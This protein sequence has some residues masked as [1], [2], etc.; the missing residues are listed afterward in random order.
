MTGRE[1]A[2][3][4]VL[5]VDVGTVRLGTAICERLDLPALPLDTILHK[6]RAADVAA[7]IALA[8]TR[9]A[10]TIVVGYPLRLDGTVGPAAQRID[11]FL[12]ELREAFDGDVVAVDERMTTAAAAKRLAQGELSGSRR[13]E[14]VDRLAAVEIL[15]SFRARKRRERP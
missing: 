8:R 4:P 5:A 1:R 7:V 9:G 14:L 15:E 2:T 10:G 13:R 6:G 3:G 12:A 11:R